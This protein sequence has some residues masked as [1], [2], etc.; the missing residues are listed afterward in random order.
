M[1][2]PSDYTLDPSQSSE[3]EILE[4][5]MAARRLE[6]NGC[7]ELNLKVS[8][9]YTVGYRSYWLNKQTNALSPVVV[10]WAGFH[11]ATAVLELLFQLC[12]VLEL[13]AYTNIHDFVCNWGRGSEVCFL[14]PALC[15]FWGSSSAHWAYMQASLPLRYLVSSFM[16]SALI[17]PLLYAFSLFLQWKQK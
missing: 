5:G 9:G 17:L 13:Q 1:C 12:Q 15:G 14:L 2:S 11:V 3:K 6:K 10:F 7:C 16:F 4:P 8:L